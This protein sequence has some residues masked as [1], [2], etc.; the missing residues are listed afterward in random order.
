MSR[1]DLIPLLL[2]QAAPPRNVHA[3]FR[4]VL[5]DRQ[6]GGDEQWLDVVDPKKAPCPWEEEVCP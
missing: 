6:G 1:T 4:M 5:Q 2:A 3:L